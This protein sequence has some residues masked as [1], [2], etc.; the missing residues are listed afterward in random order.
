MCRS[1][2]SW[3]KDNETLIALVTWVVSSAIRFLSPQLNA[4]AMKSWLPPRCGCFSYVRPIALPT[5]R[6]YTSFGD[7]IRCDALRRSSSLSSGKPSYTIYQ[8]L[9]QRI[10]DPA[11]CWRRGCFP[12]REHQDSTSIAIFV[13]T[14]FR[15][16]R[17]GYE[18]LNSKG[19]EHQDSASIAIFVGTGLGVERFGRSPLLP[20]PSPHLRN[21]RLTV[22]A[23][24]LGHCP[25]R[26]SQKGSLYCK[27]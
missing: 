7:Q 4:S 3:P 21:S 20:T 1:T 9:W 23:S 25:K 24:V 26:A 14:S 13:G 10:D 18:R 17:L 15:V 19:R 12:S 2:G 16:K 27:H 5:G 6:S 11:E 22:A 8:T